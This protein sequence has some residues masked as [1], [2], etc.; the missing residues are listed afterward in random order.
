MAGSRE[1]HKEQTE[2]NKNPICGCESICQ[3]SSTLLLISDVYMIKL[4]W[5]FTFLLNSCLWKGYRRSI[6]WVTTSWNAQETN[7]IRNITLYIHNRNFLRKLKLFICCRC[8]SIAGRVFRG[9][10]EKH[11]REPETFLDCCYLINRCPL[12]CTKFQEDQGK[13][14]DSNHNGHSHNVKFATPC[15]HTVTFLTTMKISST[16]VFVAKIGSVNVW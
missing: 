1:I 4:Y 8:Y 6:H 14:P 2:G 3:E 7:Y 13:A 10:V 9:F 12:I 11:F 5:F 15:N 16:Y